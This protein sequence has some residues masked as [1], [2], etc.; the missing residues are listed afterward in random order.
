M[1]PFKSLISFK[2]DVAGHLIRI[3]E[4]IREELSLYKDSPFY[5]LLLYAADA[6]KR[7]RPLIL[8]LSAESVGNK[9]ED[10][11]PAAVAIELSHIESLIHDDIIDQESSRRGKPPVLVKFGYIPALLSADYILAI[12]LNIVSRYNDRR[13]PREFASTVFKMCTGEL[14][15]HK[16]TD[17]K[18]LTFD[19]YINIIENKTASLF[20]ASAKIGA[21]IGG[22]EE[23]EIKMLSDFG[24]LL[25][26]SYQI[27][28][29]LS[30]LNNDMATFNLL[31]K[32]D[33]WNGM[34]KP[35]E[36]IRRYSEAALKCLKPLKETRAKEQ[37][38][39]LAEFAFL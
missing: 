31:H 27:K 7:I 18:S 39:S 32:I 34:E 1:V 35:E 17:L 4:A 9:G 14:T 36:V 21:I 8:L 28:D 25:G 24:R 13:I 33:G 38:I 5:E 20:S 19:E 12:I 16:S 26:S 6:G 30:D 2:A 3:E 37:L 11:L 29:D 10:S 23:W 22:G 15:E